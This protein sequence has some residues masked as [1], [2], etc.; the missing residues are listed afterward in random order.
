MQ[1]QIRQ[2]VSNEAWDGVRYPDAYLM[3]VL[4]YMRDTAHVPTTAVWLAM[5][6]DFF[7]GYIIQARWAA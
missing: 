6:A 4:L 5:Y 3:D 2:Y 7:T 1:C